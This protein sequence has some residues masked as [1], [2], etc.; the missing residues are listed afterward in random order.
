M[1]IRRRDMASRI[2]DV[3]RS[4]DIPESGGG[5]HDMASRSIDTKRPSVQGGPPV[6]MCAAGNEATYD[7]YI[8]QHEGQK[9]PH[10]TDRMAGAGSPRPQVLVRFVRF[11]YAQWHLY[12]SPT[13]WVVYMLH[14]DGKDMA[15]LS[16]TLCLYHRA[17]RSCS[18]CAFL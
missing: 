17:F 18:W 14:V 15:G 6:I 10:D 7:L 4:R 9:Q 11:L 13:I 2:P 1:P 16:P 3:D 12:N 8:I 5:L